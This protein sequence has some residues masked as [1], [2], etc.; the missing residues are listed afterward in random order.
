MKLSSPR[1]ARR[2]SLR[3]C[4]FDGMSTSVAGRLSRWPLEP[5]APCPTEH[6]APTTRRTSISGR[7][8]T[9]CPAY[10][11]RLG[12]QSGPT[13]LRVY[14][15]PL[16]LL[17]KSSAVLISGVRRG[18]QEQSFVPLGLVARLGVT[19]VSLSPGCA[20]RQLPASEAPRGQLLAPK[21]LA[22]FVAWPSPATPPHCDPP[23]REG[24]GRRAC[25]C[26][27]LGYST[28]SR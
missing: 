20:R 11:P 8:A 16:D 3:R 23:C 1:R 7:V 21:Y 17:G 4:R 25:G 2:Q 22:E 19:Q 18:T 6:I 15:A 10:R 24:E 5:A 26:V 13:A 12:R 14:L 28:E 27:R 9:T